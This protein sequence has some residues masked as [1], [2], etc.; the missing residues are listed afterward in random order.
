MNNLFQKTLNLLILFC[1]LMKPLTVLQIKNSLMRI[2]LI[3]M[4][5]SK[6]HRGCI[7]ILNLLVLHE[8]LMQWLTEALRDLDCDNKIVQ[9]SM[10]GP[11][12]N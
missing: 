5:T 4:N 9:V 8:H 2:L 6:E 12:V 7:L 11:N 3:L 1:V 10:D